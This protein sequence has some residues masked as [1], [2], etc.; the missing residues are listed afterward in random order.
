M[1]RTIAT[2]LALLAL[3]VAGC[4]D[5]DD[6]GA[7]AGGGGGGGGEAKLAFVYPTTTTNFAQEMALGAKAAADDTDGVKLVENPSLLKVTTIKKKYVEQMEKMPYKD[8]FRLMRAGEVEIVGHVEGFKVV[9]VS[10]DQYRC[11]GAEVFNRWYVEIMDEHG[12]RI[13]E[14]S[15]GRNKSIYDFAHERL[16]ALPQLFTD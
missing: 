15:L 11:I 12:R 7:G 4:G 13:I 8:F 6:G 2:G 1:T 10:G 5:D 3:A 14:E 16:L 9:V